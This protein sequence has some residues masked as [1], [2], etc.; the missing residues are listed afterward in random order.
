MIK[1]SESTR[2]EQ[3]LNE[4]IRKCSNEATLTELSECVD[5]GLNSEQLTSMKI[6]AEAFEDKTVLSA[7]AMRY[8][9]V[10]AEELLKKWHVTKQEVFSNSLKDGKLR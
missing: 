2:T 6:K 4:F 10:A 7:L 9:Q 5:K 8:T 3:R 1:L